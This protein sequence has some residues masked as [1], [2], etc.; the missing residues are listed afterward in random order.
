MTQVMSQGCAL[1]AIFAKNAG[2]LAAFVPAE[3]RTGRAEQ[4]ALTK[5]SRVLKGL[6]RNATCGI[7]RKL[8]WHT[9]SSFINQAPEHSK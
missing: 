2:F 4:R 7:G 1:F 3:L 8:Q 5:C 6:P 9:A